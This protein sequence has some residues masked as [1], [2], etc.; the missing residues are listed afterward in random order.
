MAEILDMIK[1]KYEGS[2]IPTIYRIVKIRARYDD[3]ISM[4]CDMEI[5]WNYDD[6]C[7]KMFDLDVSGWEISEGITEEAQK[8]NTETIYN[9][10]T[11]HMTR[12]I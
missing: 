1:E 8:S 3:S 9:E 10:V 2:I 7:V 12:T 5:A 11:I 6:L 4:L